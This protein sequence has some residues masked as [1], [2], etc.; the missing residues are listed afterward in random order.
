MSND[1]KFLVKKDWEYSI[2]MT[3]SVALIYMFWVLLTALP[4]SFQAL[5]HHHYY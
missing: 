1:S 2:G 4:V 3:A 5:F